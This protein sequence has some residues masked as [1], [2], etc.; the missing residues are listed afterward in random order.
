MREEILFERGTTLVRRLELQPSEVL[1]WHT[2]PFHRVSV[3]L[4]GEL[5]EIEYRDSGERKHIE[6]HPGEVGWDEP[7]GRPHRATNL[8]APYEEITVFFLDRPG[9]PHQPNA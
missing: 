9:A 7:T 2:D 3:V 4:K 1:P 5:L 8:G 6:V